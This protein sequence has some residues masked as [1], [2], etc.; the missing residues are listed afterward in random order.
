MTVTVKMMGDVNLF[1]QVDKQFWKH[2][3]PHLTYNI[4][5]AVTLTVP[6]A[7]LCVILSDTV[8][9]TPNSEHFVH[10][11]LVRILLHCKL[12]WLIDANRALIDIIRKQASSDAAPDLSAFIDKGRLTQKLPLS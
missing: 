10:L 1:C 8:G 3:P 5:L 9:S 7:G 6:R 12:F 4:F 2:R 11:V